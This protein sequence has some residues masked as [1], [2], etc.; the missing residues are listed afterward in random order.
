MDDNVFFKYST[1]ILGRM[2]NCPRYFN[3]FSDLNKIRLI[4]AYER[5]LEDDL[6]GFYY[7]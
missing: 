3:R 7:E 5:S 4:I 2:I 1:S 6:W